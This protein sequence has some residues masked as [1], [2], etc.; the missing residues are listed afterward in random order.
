MCSPGILSQINI[1]FRRDVK[2]YSWKT[3]CFRGNSLVEYGLPL[4][5]VGILL[6]GAC[7]TLNPSMKSFLQ[8]SLSTQPLQNT[9]TAS[10]PVQTLAVQK[11]GTSPL[12]TE[13][14]VTLSDGTQIRLSNFPKD[15]K[16]SIESVGANGTTDLLANALAELAQRLRDAG[17]IDDRQFQSLIKLSQKG[18]EA[19]RMQGL[20]DD[21][22]ERSKRDGT[23]FGN[24]IIQYD[25]K[26]IPALY[27]ARLLGSFV[28][29]KN[30]KNNDPG[31]EY[32]QFL[33]PQDSNFLRENL[34][35]Q[36]KDNA[37]GLGL[38]DLVKSFQGTFT[39][40]TM[41][42]PV[43]K[44]LVS[45]LTSNI[46]AMTQGTAGATNDYANN[47]IGKAI[48]AGDKAINNPEAFKS[49][50]QES[51]GNSQISSQHICIIGRGV[52]SGT[53]CQG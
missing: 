1:F 10:T 15:L 29:D 6:I 48:M 28:G 12:T 7:L 44:N 8:S 50:V 52:D 22:L 36:L 32:I 26:S 18:H 34:N 9:G 23:P 13:A 24:Q 3:H 45:Q 46:Y 47:S 5:L 51:I 42:E 20:I 16:Q 4:S 39:S 40:G 41:Q 35:L 37:M 11:L 43:L 53:Q 27:F 33:T 14:I 31:A 49:K 30:V 2:T 25:G 21:A 19:A 38:Y 17:K